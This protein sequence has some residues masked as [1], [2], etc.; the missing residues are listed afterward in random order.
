MKTCKL[1]APTHKIPLSERGCRAPRD[2]GVSTRAEKYTPLT[3]LKRG[4]CKQ[5]YIV[6]NRGWL[7]HGQ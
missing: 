3:P 4:I 7:A 5:G 6:V 1:I 2:R